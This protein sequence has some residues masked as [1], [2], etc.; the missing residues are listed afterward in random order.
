[1]RIFKIS[2]FYSLSFVVLMGC[3]P[4][5]E[6]YTPDNKAVEFQKRAYALVVKD[7]GNKVKVEKAILLL[8]SAIQIDD[9]YFG[10]Y[11]S[12]LQLYM[13]R[14]DLANAIIV[15]QKLNELRPH[16]PVWKVQRGMLYELDGQQDN[17][18]ECFKAALS[19]FE[20]MMDENP[21]IHW[22][23]QLEYAES[24]MMVGKEKEGRALY[25]KI[26]TAIPNEKFWSKYVLKTRRKMIEEWDQEPK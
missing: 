23:F 4:K 11:W 20:K 17:A 13:S 26:K 6:V 1:M 19:K 24:L 10:A 15:N 14:K 21:N 22:Q 8:D 9:K 3:K 16:Q 25:E 18:D 12:K 7:W 2:I 5:K